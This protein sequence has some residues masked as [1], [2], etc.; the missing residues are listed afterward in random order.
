M[1]LARYG[2]AF[3]DRAVARSVQHQAIDL[4]AP[5]GGGMGVGLSDP[6]RVRYFIQLLYKGAEHVRGRRDVRAE[7]SAG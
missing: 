2:H 6:L 1:E 4:D 3:K 5:V 7:L